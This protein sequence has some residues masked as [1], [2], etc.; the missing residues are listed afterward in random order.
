M[1]FFNN[2]YG[3][4]GLIYTEFMV[5]LT[6]AIVS[7]ILWLFDP[8]DWEKQILRTKVFK[9]VHETNNKCVMTQKEANEYL[10]FFLFY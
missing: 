7:P 9:E 5:F 4:G 2:V 6:N 1:I 8:W 3:E 10:Y